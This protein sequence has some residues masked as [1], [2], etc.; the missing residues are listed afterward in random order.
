[1]KQ[2]LKAWQASLTED[3]RAN[4]REIRRLC[5]ALTRAAFDEEKNAYDVTP[6]EYFP[7][8]LERVF[9]DGGKSIDL[10]DDAPVVIGNVRDSSCARIS[11]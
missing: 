4:M 9:P 3:A 1:M 11:R 10:P 5:Q 6:D 2:N 7:A 8:V